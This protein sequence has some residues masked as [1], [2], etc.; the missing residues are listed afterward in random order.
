MRLPLRKASPP[1]CIC[2]FNFTSG[3]QRYLDIGVDK[4]KLVVGLPWYGYNYACIS[5]SD[6]E[7][8]IR[9]VPFRGVNCSD[10][11][12]RQYDYTVI[13]STYIPQAIGGVQWDENA[14]SPF[15]NYKD[16]SDD[17]IHQVW[18]DNPY[19]LQIKYQ[20]LW[21]D[22]GVRGLAMWN[23]D[24]AVDEKDMWAALPSLN[25]LP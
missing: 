18:F 10:A 15:F 4:K 21:H 3:V 12:G 14:Q 22:L 25:L 19:S 11:A 13:K 5:L 23:V 9:R 8:Q 6:N 24:C 20:L 16:L 7:C 17:Q 1:V 2:T